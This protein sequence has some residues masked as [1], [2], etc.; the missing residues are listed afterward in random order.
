MEQSGG[1]SLQRGISNAY[2]FTTAASQAYGSNQ[3]LVGSKYCVFS[4]DVNGDG[5]ID[6]TDNVMI[7]NDAFAFATGFLVTDLNGDYTIDGT[8]LIIAD[9][10]AFNFVAVIQP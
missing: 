4:G 6:G 8:D 5:A 10:N 7:D 1:E 9:N 2:D 3:K